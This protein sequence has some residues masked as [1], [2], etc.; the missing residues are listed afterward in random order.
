MVGSTMGDRGG[1]VGSTAS[2]VKIRGGWLS[3]DIVMDVFL[4]AIMI[5]LRSFLGLFL[6][7]SHRMRC[8]DMWNDNVSVCEAIF[9]IPHKYYMCNQYK[10]IGFM[11]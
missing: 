7:N 8:K 11:V 10:V 4:D 1:V 9:S 5:S 3:P 2:G 6:N